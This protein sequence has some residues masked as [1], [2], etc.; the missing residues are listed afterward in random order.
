MIYYS[1][2]ICRS[3][4]EK[5]LIWYVAELNII[6]LTKIEIII[7]YYTLLCS[8]KRLIQI[9]VDSS[10]KY[11]Y[12]EWHELITLSSKLTKKVDIYEKSLWG[13]KNYIIPFQK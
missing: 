7:K 3:I 10:A 1:C 2:Q 12:V 6:L 13:I 11:V 8:I 5:D 4:H 9:L